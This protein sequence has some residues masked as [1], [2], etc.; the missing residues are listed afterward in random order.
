M[1][2]RLMKLISMV[3]TMTMIDYSTGRPLCTGQQGRAM[4]RCWS[5]WWNR[6]PLWMLPMRWVDIGGGG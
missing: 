5:G 3:A 1:M 6:E 2:T 4:G